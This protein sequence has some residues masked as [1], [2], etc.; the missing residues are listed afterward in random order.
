MTEERKSPIV[1]RVQEFCCTMCGKKA[2]AETAT[3][4]HPE[5]P[6]MIH[7]APEL[8]QLGKLGPLALRGDWWAGMVA[9]KE[10][11]DVKGWLVLVCSHDCLARL[12]FE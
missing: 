7:L 3:T 4:A 10:G 1:F 2:V 9:D 5:S 6:M 12:L 8:E 11:E